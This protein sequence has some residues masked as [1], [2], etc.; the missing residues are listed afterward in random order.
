[1]KVI[2]LDIDG[3]LCTQ[4]EIY[5]K[6]K[7]KKYTAVMQCIDG[8]WLLNFNTEAVRCLN[9]ITDKTNAKLVISSCWRNRGIEILRKHFSQQGVTGELFDVTG[10][11]QESRGEEIETWLKNHRDCEK[12]IILDDE[13]D[14]EPPISEFLVKTNWYSEEEP[15][16]LNFGLAEKAI[17]LLNAS[18]YN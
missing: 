14:M 8:R 13:S 18:L 10:K 12:F 6:K 2:F 16:G 15:M 3:V 11:H 1:M 9:H 5:Y 4:E 7:D 17:S